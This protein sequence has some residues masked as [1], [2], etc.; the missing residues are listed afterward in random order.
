MSKADSER[1]LSAR[2]HPA[3][4][5]ARSRQSNSKMRPHPAAQDLDEELL[6]RRESLRDEPGRVLMDTSHLVIES[7]SSDDH[8]RTEVGGLK[9]SAPL[10]D[11]LPIAREH[12]RLDR[13]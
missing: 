2:R 11:Q 7:M 10:R 5:C 1:E 3:Y 8:R 13:V 9:R 6:M 12:D 4:R